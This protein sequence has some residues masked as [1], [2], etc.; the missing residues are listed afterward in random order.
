MEENFEV[1][2][3]NICGQIFN[4]KTSDRGAIERSIEK[5]EERIEKICE[6]GKTL[7]LQNAALL[8]ALSFSGELQRAQEEF[9]TFKDEITSRSK[10][11]L[12]VMESFLKEKNAEK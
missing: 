4:L 3:V 12:G 8:A 7:S 11:M 5:V 6:K 1:V 9:E 10:R 2:E